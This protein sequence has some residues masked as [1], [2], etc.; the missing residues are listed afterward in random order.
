MNEVEEV[1]YLTDLLLSA[2]RWIRPDEDSAT[3]LELEIQ[4]RINRLTSLPTDRIVGPAEPVEVKP[5]YCAQKRY[6]ENKV[7]VSWMDD[8][9]QTHRSWFNRELCKQIPIASGRNKMKWV[10]KEPTELDQEQASE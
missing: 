7:R 10:L 4:D 3:G 9:G 2:T 8:A 5:T 1:R 6:T